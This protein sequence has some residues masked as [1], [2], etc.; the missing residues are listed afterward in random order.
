LRR[1]LLA[2]LAFLAACMSN[3]PAPERVVTPPAAVPTL[4]PLHTPGPDPHS[5]ARPDEARVSHMGL[6]LTVDF[7]A[8]VLSGTATLAVI[9]R[10]D[11]DQLIL[12]TRD[13]TIERIEVATA[14]APT[15]GPLR[16]AGAD[17]L[18]WRETPWQLGGLHPVL[19]QPLLVELPATVD[20]VRVTYRTTPTASGLQW[21]S[22][23]QTADHLAPFLYTQ[24][25][26]IHARSW[27]PV[28]DSPGIRITFDARVHSPAPTRPVM[29]AE[30]LSVETGPK[31][32]VYRFAL[33]R[34]I[35]PYLLALA[36]GRLEPASIGPRTG[37]W[38]E[39]S[40]LA[41]ARAEFADLEAMLTTTEQQF[42]PYRWGRY[43]VLVLP[44]AFPFGGMENPRVTFV[45][46]T[47]LAGDRSLVALIAHELAHSWSGNLVSNATWRDLWL[48]EG[49]TVYLERRI[50]E[51]IYG[52]ER[53]EI[54]AALGRQDLEAD[55][56][57]L[58][59]HPG[60]TVLH[61]DL[62]GRDPDD[63]FSDVPYEKGYLLLRR[64][65][66]AIGRPAFDAA[67]TQW[68]A[69]HAFTSQTTAE[70]LRCFAEVLRAHPALPGQSAPDLEQWL[71]TPGLLPDT[72]RAHAPALDAVAAAAVSFTRGE[73]PASKL[74]VRGWTPQH[75]IY[76]LRALPLTT[77]DA[78]ARLA[79]LDAAFHLG[80]SSNNEILAQW[81]L[82]AAVHDYRAADP[83]LERFLC[84]VGRR[85]YLTPIYEALLASANGQPRAREIYA[86]ARPGYHP[87]TQHSLDT[88]LARPTLPALDPTAPL[89]GLR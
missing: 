89:A 3:A 57:A 23:E 60:D 54:E 45:T 69:D 73:L 78:V 83:R 25:Q 39:P 38:A 21:L 29:A 49:F 5:F 48:N 51:A 42:G 33:D 28:Q 61:V 24:S 20:R 82:L 56:A 74:P 13:L 67:L 27:L 12:D 16:I 10:A 9:R 68:F 1:S 62:A 53:A 75:W 64:I 65:E 32:Q 50:V 17:D 22:P 84:E 2:P 26:A 52:A 85:K 76:F 46:P 81:L 47:I 58:A 15:P 7:D 87:I 80:A 34:S 8:R 41:R 40:L 4:P 63:V 19:G 70:F 66:Q 71:T 37:V 43:E 30:A 36:V 79:E 86:K 35:P 6:D 44:P 77:A 88:L 11:A 18:T 55:L 59:D 14:L 72:P 31:G